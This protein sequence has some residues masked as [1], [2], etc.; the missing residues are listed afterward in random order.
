MIESLKKINT[1]WWIFYGLFFILFVSYSISFSYNFPNQDDL[2]FINFLENFLHAAT[3][4]DYFNA[5]FYSENDHIHTFPRLIV[6]FQYILS[7]ELN[8]IYLQIIA[9]L[10]LGICLYLVIKTLV[11][12]ITTLQLIPLLHI[13]L[14]PSYY[15]LSNWPF[16][17]LCIFT[18]I[19]LMNISFTLF[20]REKYRNLSYL[21]A[22]FATF[23]FGN[24][25][26]TFVIT[27]LILLL[28]KKWKNCTSNDTRYH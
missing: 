20:Q 2:N 3:L 15:E 6:Y 25:I 5:L 27:G 10:E 4:K 8:Y 7:N 11:P 28:E 26:L 23:S 16:S 17:G 1:N 18:A 9:L 12:S 24:G 14:Q 21:F 22:F 13:V 19:L